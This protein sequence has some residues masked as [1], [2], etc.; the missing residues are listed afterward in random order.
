MDAITHDKHIQFDPAA[1]LGLKLAAFYWMVLDHMDWL[2]FDG[3]GAHASVGRLVFPIFGVVIAYNMARVDLQT[4]SRMF[5]RLAAIAGITTPVYA[6]LTGYVLPLNIMFTLAAAV[7]VYLLAMQEREYLAILAGFAAGVV[8]DYAWFGVFGVAG[9]ALAMRARSQP[10]LGWCAFV[11]F[12]ASL[13]AIN[14]NLWA[15][16]A[17]PMVWAMSAI[18]PGAAPRMKWLFWVGYPAH[19]GILALVK[20]AM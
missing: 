7:G 11:L 1:L 17:V 16:A 8:C 4:L 19:L 2:L 6:Y 20:L 9:M 5:G 15:L 3:Q 18:R 12:A 13:T 10:W 14:G